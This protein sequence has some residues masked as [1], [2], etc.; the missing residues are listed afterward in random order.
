MEGKSSLALADIDVWTLRSPRRT[1]TAS[2][3]LSPVSSQLWWDQSEDIKAPECFYIEEA[4]REH[5]DLS[6]M[7]TSMA[8]RS[9]PLPPS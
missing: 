3:R 5:E 6:S 9:S 2:S 7:T 4:L 1:P 8:L